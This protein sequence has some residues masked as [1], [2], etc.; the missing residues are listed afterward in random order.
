MEKATPIDQAQLLLNEMI[1]ITE[2]CMKCCIS[3]EKCSPGDAAEIASTVS[4]IYI[5]LVFAELKHQHATEIHNVL[6]QEFRKV[7]PT[8]YGKPVSKFFFNI[9]SRGNK[10]AD[11]PLATVREWEAVLYDQT[12]GE[13]SEDTVWGIFQEINANRPGGSMLY[14]NGPC[15]SSDIT[16]MIL[17]HFHKTRVMISAIVA[18][19]S[20]S[21]YNTSNNG[22]Q[23]TRHKVPGPLTP[24]VR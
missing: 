7:A 23:S 10:A 14:S 18:G 9:F 3:P 1:F 12:S 19:E 6:T 4:R 20:S 21:D 11:L 8:L 22:V 2:Q 16:K 15:R 17:D 5:A 13:I 24:D